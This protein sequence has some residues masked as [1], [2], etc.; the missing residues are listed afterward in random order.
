MYVFL[1]EQGKNL[2]DIIDQLN[3][4]NWQTWMKSFSVT[5][6]VEIRFPKI[7]YEYEIK[8]ND[9]LTEMGMGVAFTGAADLPESTAMADYISIT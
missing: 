1:P 3:N 7:K 5:Q 4:E 6:N 2:Q 9:I 8:L